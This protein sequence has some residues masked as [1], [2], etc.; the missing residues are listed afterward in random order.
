MRIKRWIYTGLLTA[1]LLMSS[2]GKE[3]NDGVISSEGRFEGT[4]LITAEEA[5][6][7]IGDEDVQFL[8]AR[9]STKALLGTVKGAVV[10]RWKELSTCDTGKAG[11]AGWGLVPEADDLAARLGDLG[12]D[13]E[14]EIIVLGEPQDGWGED[15]RILWE[16]VQAGFENVKIVDGGIQAMKAAG[17]KMQLG[18]STPEKT[19][20]AIEEL[21]TANNITT[22]ELQENYDSFKI[23]DVRTIEEYEGAI[24]HD[25]AQG[26]HLPGAVNVPFVDMFTAEG[27]LK[28]NDEISAMLEAYEIQK[29]DEIVVY[30]TGG[31]RS[32]YA[33]LVLEMCGYDNTRNYGQSFWR[34]AVVGEVE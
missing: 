7:K 9:G 2:C 14:K 22:E 15:G 17:A 13:K 34:W 6:E 12:L 3:K 27:V 32:A 23:V 20:V 10:T 25:E 16:L 4:Y 18:G 31:I 11:D 1:C 26:G 8:D 33:Q 19:E 5:V 24:L 28:S 29:E 21:N 30:C